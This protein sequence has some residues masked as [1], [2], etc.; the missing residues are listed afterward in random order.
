MFGASPTPG[1][2]DAPRPPSRRSRRLGDSA[3]DGSERL[4]SV[5]R[6]DVGTRTVSPFGGF[7]AAFG[8]LFF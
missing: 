3:L 5:E 8:M 6:V 1:H 7:E 2:S 4:R